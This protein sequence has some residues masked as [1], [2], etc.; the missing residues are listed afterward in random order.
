MTTPPRLDPAAPLAEVVPPAADEAPPARG[1]VPTLPA[2]APAPARPVWAT[3]RPILGGLVAVAILVFGFFGWS[4][5]TQIAGAI[6]T[7]GQIE[8]ESNRQ[9][10]QHPDG[11]VIEEIR[12][13]EGATVAAGDVLIRLDGT[14]LRSELAIV[15]GQLYETIARRARLEAERDDATEIRFP[16]SLT[17][18]AA[19]RPEVAAQIEGQARLFTARRET[20]AK[21]AEQLRRQAT[22]TQDQITG[23]DAQASALERQ[24]TLIAQEL[25]DA[26]SLLEKGLAQQSRVLALEREEASL[27]GQI[28]QL[29]ANRAQAEGTISRIELEILRLEALRREE[30]TAELR[31]VGPAELEL[32]E[33][34]RSLTERVARLDVRAPVS[35][36]VLGLQYTTP[37]AVIRPADPVLYLI[38]QDRPLVIA[39]QVPPI[40]IDQVHP[41]Q[42]VELIFSSFSTRTTPHLKGHVHVVSADA[43]RDEATGM[44]FY[45]AEVVLDE[46]EMEKLGGLQLLPGMPVEAFI[47]TDLRTPLAYMLKP[48]TDYFAHAFRES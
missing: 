21:Q 41:G 39:T 37:R 40:H 17:A 19:T 36:I 18:L 43:F 25:A 5:F 35:G 31:E 16:D 13:E 15:E 10:V 12:V 28:G 9:V 20:L 23:I 3:R 8:V 33:R 29:T 45:R 7:S 48:F 30:A 47:Q 32:A 14:L 24:L 26:K 34:Q 46:G 2:P 22:Q 11:G 6:V 4:L 44:S 42:E 27:T 38:P 1:Q